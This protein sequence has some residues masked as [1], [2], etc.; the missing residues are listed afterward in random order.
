MF[1]KID[2]KVV[3]NNYRIHFVG[4]IGEDRPELAAEYLKDI[5]HYQ[6]LIERRSHDRTDSASF[7]EKSRLDAQIESL[8]K[9]QNTLL[10]ELSEPLRVDIEKELNITRQDAGISMSF[11]Q[12]YG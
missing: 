4:P 8:K 2:S 3:P 6:T 1:K 11:G 5:R 7:V 10:I 9:A 12:A